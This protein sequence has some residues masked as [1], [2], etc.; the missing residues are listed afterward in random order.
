MQVLITLVLVLGFVSPS[1]CT[2]WNVVEANNN[3]NTYNV[4]QYGASGDGKS[5]D[6]QVNMFLINSRLSF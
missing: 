5:D 3:N 4:M 1:L 6:S 2:R